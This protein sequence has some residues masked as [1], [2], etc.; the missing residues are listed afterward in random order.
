MTSPKSERRPYAAPRVHVYS[1]EELQA[2]L[3]PAHASYGNPP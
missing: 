3:G 2:A 1:A